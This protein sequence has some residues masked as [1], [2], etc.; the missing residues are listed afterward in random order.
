MAATI[1]VTDQCPHGTA[2]T[3]RSPGAARARRRAITV[4]A[5]ASST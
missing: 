4:V 3:A 2:P 5:A 1:V